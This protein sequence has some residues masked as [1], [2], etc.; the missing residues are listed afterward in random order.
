MISLWL[1][2]LFQRISVAIYRFYSELLHDTDCRLIGPIAVI[3]RALKRAQI[4]AAK[5]P[6]S[7]VR[8]DN[9]RPDG[10]TLLPWARGKPMAWDVTVPDTYAESH[11]S[12]AVTPCAAAHRAAQSKT[13]KYTKLASTHIFCPFAIETAGAWHETAIEV[14]QEIGRR[15][16]V[17]T[18]DTLNI[19]ACGF[20]L[21][22]LIIII[23]III[24]LHCTT[25]W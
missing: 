1:L 9:E 10:T 24:C 5:E 2:L 8:D 18:E 19:S 14:T 25:I 15:I 7:L 17:V 20:V 11:S 3:W 22:G 23:I 4:P 13:D 12:T 16:T 21:V 6:V